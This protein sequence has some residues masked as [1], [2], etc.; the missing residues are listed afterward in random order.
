MA[1]LYLVRHGIAEPAELAGGSD[2][3]RR[4]T[5]KGAQRAREVARGLCSLGV[6]VDRIFTSPLP[7]ARETAEILIEE[8]DLARDCL[9][10]M[11]LLRP[12]SSPAEIAEWLG[13][14]ALNS[15][16]LVGHN[17][18]LSNL[19]SYLITGGRPGGPTFE[20]KKCGIACLELPESETARLKWLAEPRLLRRL[21]GD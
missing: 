5:A 4:L 6:T 17:P 2:E 11:T 10:E 18:S 3:E 12:E 15:I 20:L 1:T 21:R 19:I 8:L 16:S 7:R 9:T 13:G 14:L